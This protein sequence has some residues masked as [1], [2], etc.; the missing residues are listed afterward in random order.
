MKKLTFMAAVTMTLVALGAVKSAGADNKHNGACVGFAGSISG[1]AYAGVKCYLDSAPGDYVVRYAVKKRDDP[2]VYK[3]ILGIPKHPVRCT[4]TK[5][6]T[7]R[8]GGM[9]NT[10]YHIS[11]C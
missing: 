3:K 6:K 11:N 9:V 2:K 7:T 1:Q 4:L 8:S 5:G 10:H